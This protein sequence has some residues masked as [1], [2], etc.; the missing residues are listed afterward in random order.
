MSWKWEQLI[1]MDIN[2]NHRNQ[3]NDQ[4]NRTKN[5]RVHCHEDERGFQGGSFQTIKNLE[6]WLLFNSYGIP[7]IWPWPFTSSLLLE[8]SGFSHVQPPLTPS[9]IH[10]FLTTVSKYS[11]LHQICPQLR[12]DTF[13]LPF[14]KFVS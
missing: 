3:K 12:T 11:L 5:R 13:Y 9:V 1:Y 4:R 7:T 6:S 14:Y 8:S 10:W 2:W